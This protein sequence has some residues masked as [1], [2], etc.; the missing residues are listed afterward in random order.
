V[1]DKSGS[2]FWKEEEDDPKTAIQME[3]K[4]KIKKD[5][6]GKKGEGWVFPL[7]SPYLERI[8]SNK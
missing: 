3:K 8:D 4:K 2:W 6:G 5:S 7:N 1:H